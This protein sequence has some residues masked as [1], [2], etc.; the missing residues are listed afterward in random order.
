MVSFITYIFLFCSFYF[1]KLRLSEFKGVGGSCYIAVPCL[2]QI[3]CVFVIYLFIYLF[4]Y[5][6][7]L[8]VCV[9]LN[10]FFVSF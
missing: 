7:F 1:R 8:Y 10:F 6:A 9:S 5:F 3:S 4:I 2:Q